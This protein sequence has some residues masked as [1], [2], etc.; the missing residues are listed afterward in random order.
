M[1]PLFEQNKCPLRPYMCIICLVIYRMA[2]DQNDLSTLDEHHC[3]CSAKWTE[4]VHRNSPMSV[5]KSNQVINIIC[6][7][8]RINDAYNDTSFI[9]IS[10]EPL[11]TSSAR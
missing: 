11:D 7:H 3:T 2:F 10:R 8:C 6:Y 5:N 9:V 1:I 4:L